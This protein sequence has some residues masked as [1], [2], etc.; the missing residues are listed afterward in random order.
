M[1]V[2]AVTAS[3]ICSPSTEIPLPQCFDVLIKHCRGRLAEERSGAPLTSAAHERQG[4]A[5]CRSRG[6]GTA[7]LMTLGELNMM[8][9]AALA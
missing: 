6:G 9:K 1:L 5:C 2:N 4:S 8:R 7:C 3:L